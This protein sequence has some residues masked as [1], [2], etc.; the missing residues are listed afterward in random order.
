M[1]SAAKLET[2]GAV[3]GYEV[4]SSFACRFLRRPGSGDPL[5]LRETAREPQPTTEPLLEWTPRPLRDFTAKL[6]AQDGSF[7]FWT[8]REGWFSID[9]ETPSITAQAGVDPIRREARLWGVPALLC[10]MRRG[11][12]PIHAAAVEVGG[13]AL[14]FPAPGRNG[15]TTIASA[16]LRAGHRVLSED[17]TCCDT[18]QTPSLY[19]GPAMLRVRRDVYENL[20]I[21]STHPVAEDEDR[22]HLALDDDARGD[23]S[24][25]PIAGVVFLRRGDG[26]PP[27]VERRAARASIPDLWALSM[28]LPTEEDRSRCFQGVAALAGSVPT[29]NLRRDF[30]LAR[31][32]DVVSLVIDACL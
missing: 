11:N 7:Q 18:T 27:V 10:Y 23:G 16:F 12:I 26:A 30:S 28:N 4:R 3:H 9:P 20:E 17:L 15:K 8:N 21:P 22:V 14:L 5:E 24:P 29:W 19:P 13:R 2:V 32:D 25:V 6:F 1:A 31:I